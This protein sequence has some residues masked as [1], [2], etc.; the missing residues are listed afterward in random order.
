MKV[1]F[2]L[3]RVLLVASLVLG[4]AWALMH[5]D[6][7]DGNQVQALVHGAG[8]SGPLLLVALYM[9]STVLFVPGSLFGLAG[10]AL[11]GPVWGSL[12]N[13]LGAMLGASLSFLAARYIAADWVAR[14]AGG[15]LGQLIAG[16]EAEGWRFIAFV[17][18]VPLFPFNLLNYALGL[19]R[20]PFGQGRLH[21]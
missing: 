7:L 5:R 8:A 11:F 9:V 17:R 10:G 19:T 20:I 12:W 18:L 6:S 21:E 3:P 13:L 2:A 1:R 15:R 4:A 16:V 14:R